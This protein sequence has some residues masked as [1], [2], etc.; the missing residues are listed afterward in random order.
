M[1]FRK[2]EVRNDFL[3]P[4]RIDVQIVHFGDNPNRLFCLRFSQDDEELC[5]ICLDKKFLQDLGKTIDDFADTIDNFNG[6][7]V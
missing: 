3:F 6:A 4:N 2:H 7:P 5:R 1:A